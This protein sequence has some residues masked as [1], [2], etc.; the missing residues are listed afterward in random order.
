MARRE[1]SLFIRLFALMSLVLVFGAAVLMTAAWYSAREAADEAY[2]RLLLGAAYQIADAIQ[3]QD[4]KPEIELPVSAFELLALSDRDRIFY[5]VLDPAGHTMT[6]YEGLDVPADEAPAS[7]RALVENARFDGEIVRVARVSRRFDDPQMRG[8]AVVLVAQTVEARRALARDLTLRS[9]ILVGVMGAIAIGGTIFAVRRALAPIGRLE[10]AIRQRDPLDLTLVNVSTPR[11]LAPFVAEING[12]IERLRGRVELMQQFIA[13]AAH[14]LRTPLAAL[15]GQV[16]LL[17]NDEVTPAGGKHLERIRARTR[18]LSRLANQLLS[19]AMVAHRERA[20]A[21][22]P[23]D[24]TELTRRALD[25]AIPDTLERDLLVTLHAPP[26]PLIVSGDP[27]NLAEAI[28]NIL[29]NAVR[30]GAPGRITVRLTR[31]LDMVVVEVEDDGPGIPAG[32][33]LRVVQRFGAPSSDG[34]GSG[35]GLSIAAEVLA[36]HGGALSFVE[37]GAFGFV[38]VMSLSVKGRELA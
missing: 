27:V 8:D 6:G 33:W 3:V 21:N 10:V 31:R 28:K 30:H 4:G 36:A 7:G 32:Q 13:D 16:D 1:P 24:L 38:V 37:K 34:K 18:Q 22:A 20:V 15:E 9:F 26:E 12:F 11:E 5:R 2:D 23:V 29:D 14:Q 25:E 17:S 35:L 19:H